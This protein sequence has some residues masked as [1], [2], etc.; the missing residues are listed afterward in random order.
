MRK[1]WLGKIDLILKPRMSEIHYK[2]ERK[3]NSLLV[4]L[5][6]KGS[7]RILYLDTLK[8]IA[9]EKDREA[10]Q[11]LIKLQSRTSRHLDTLSFERIDIPAP[12][13]EEALRLMKATGRMQGETD[14]PV[15]APLVVL[16]QLVLKDQS[17]CF[18]NLWMDYEIDRIEFQDFTPTIQGRSRLKKEENQWEQDLLESGYIKKIVGDSHYYCP[19]EK[20]RESLLLLL[21]IGWQVRDKEGN[22]IQKEVSLSEEKGRIAVR[23]QLRGLIDYR[24]QLEGVWE[25]E[26]LYLKKNRCTVLLPLLESPHT[27]WEENLRLLTEGLRSGA[28]FETALPA[29]TFKGT[30]LPYQQKGVNWLNFLYQWGFSGLLADEMGLG[31]TV[32]V[33]AFLSRLRTNLP[34]LIVAPS[35]LL[36]NWQAEIRKFLDHLIQ[37]VVISYSMLR[38]NEELYAEKEFEAIVLDESNAIKTATTQTAKAACRLKGRF[39]ICISGT[40]MENRPDELWSQFHFLMPNLVEKKIDTLK[41]QVRPFVLRRT[42]EEV[43]IDLP[44]KIEQLTWIEMEEDQKEIY[45]THKK[46]VRIDGVKQT[47][48]LESILRLRQ[49]CSDPRLIG[50]EVVGAK[51]QRVVADVQEAL[52][53]KRKILIYSQFT[54]ML[55][56]LQ[57]E[58]KEAL[59]LDGSV[60]TAQRGK[61]VQAFQENPEHSLFLI[62]LKAGGVGLNLTAA[63]YVFILDPWW[64]EAVEQ[65]A[66]SR[67]HRLGRK[68]TVIAK[69][70]LMRGTIEEKMLQLKE[71]KQQTADQLL[72]FEGGHFTAEDLFALLS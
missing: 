71:K 66:I 48:I 13:V 38:L 14:R 11:L 39:K 46:G 70:Y 16:P 10:L 45:E 25:G 42:K 63:D 29:P 8:A 61:L 53:E 62:S 43:Q 40:P 57:Q 33:L 50:S 2:V 59:Y 21:E 17:G 18:A 24:L 72:D 4:K 69:R 23:S 60:A 56:L 55:Q 7:S 41:Q 67:A 22:P 52:A 58:F 36:F 1:K 26:T 47:E 3:G 32:Q 34:V 6:Q 37:F 27:Q 54:S 44:E 5:V 64:N 30:L 20:V 19:K 31:K 68:N 35:S 28:A 9:Q 65:Q 12:F 51:F 15:L 49:I